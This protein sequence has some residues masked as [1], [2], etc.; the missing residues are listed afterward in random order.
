MCGVI[1]APGRT[2]AHTHAR[3]RAVGLHRTTDRPVA[4]TSTYKHT[5][6]KRETSIPPNGFEPA[7]PTDERP[8]TYALDHPATETDCHT[9]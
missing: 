7:F 9:K 6:H 3:A 8:Q 4:E 1:V 5:T 2:H